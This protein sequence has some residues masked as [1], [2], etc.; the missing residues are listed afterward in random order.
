MLNEASDAYYNG[1]GEKMTDY[2]W[3][4]AFDELKRLESQT[5]IVL[6]DSPTARV[7]EDNVAGQ[8][9]DHEYPA[10]S[11]AKTKSVQDLVKWAEGRPVWLSWKLDGLTLVATYDN[12][13]LSKV[14]TRGNGHQGTNITR[15]APAISGILPEINYQGATSQSSSSIRTARFVVTS[16]F[17]SAR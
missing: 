2:E 7:S 13:K 12:G 8:K 5:G 4:A 6:E 14:V 9:E 1:R 11:L 10:L 15:M 16:M 3:D 17:T